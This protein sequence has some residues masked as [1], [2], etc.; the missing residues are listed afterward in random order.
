MGKPKRGGLGR[1]L[2]ALISGMSDS[3]SS[4]AASG[5]EDGGEL[6]LKLDPRTI[7]PN[8]KQPRRVFDEEALQELAASI[9]EDGVVEPVIVRSRNGEYELVS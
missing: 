9:K 4:G 1:G 6:V 8:P 3:G 2:G 5:V 7:K